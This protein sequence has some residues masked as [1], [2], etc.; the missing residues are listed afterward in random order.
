MST[1]R[2]ALP[3]EPAQPARELMRLWACELAPEWLAR[4]E[5]TTESGSW[6]HGFFIRLV[7]LSDCEIGSIGFM[8]PPDSEGDVEVAYA[9]EEAHQDQGFATEASQASQGMV[10]FVSQ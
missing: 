3:L 2:L 9:I 5:A 7:S 4:V 10:E 8:D 6:L 1:S